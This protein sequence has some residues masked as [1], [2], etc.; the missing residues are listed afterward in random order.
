MP[1]EKNCI[2]EVVRLSSEAGASLRRS[3]CKAVENYAV[4]PL[5]GYK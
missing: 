4:R 1:V 3:A 5:I 2:Q